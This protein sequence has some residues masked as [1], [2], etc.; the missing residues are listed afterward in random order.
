MCGRFTLVVDGKIITDYY[1]ERELAGYRGPSYNVAPSQYA[2]VETADGLE[3]MKWGLI[4]QWAKSASVGYSMINAVGETVFE[5]PTYKKPILY[6][7]CLVPASGFYEWL[8]T[9]DGKVPHYFT[10]KDRQIFSFAG[11]YLS[12]TDSEGRQLKTF[13]IL[14]TAPNKLVKKVHDRMPVILSREEE[15]VWIDPDMVEP[16]RISQLIDS[17]PASDMSSHVVD[18][19][20]GNAKFDDAE[21]IAPQLS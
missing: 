3:M 15:G 21:L 14:T 12:R 16:E 20:V 7:R 10:L 11:L 18:R 8:A 6:Q 17:Y 5:K 2:P 4:P 13:T 9:D 1:R 19:R